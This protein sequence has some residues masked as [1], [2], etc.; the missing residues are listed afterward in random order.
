MIN[1][2]LVNIRS[3]CK[4][5]STSKIVRKIAKYMLDLQ[6]AQ[7]SPISYIF[8]MFIAFPISSLKPPTK[9][10]TS[11]YK[12]MFQIV[13]NYS[14]NCRYFTSVNNF[15]ALFKWRSSDKVA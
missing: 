3:T 12:V 14:N 8:F 10:K 9:S 15:C 4:N 6:A 5:T 13:Q 1:W 7:K 2:L 11:I